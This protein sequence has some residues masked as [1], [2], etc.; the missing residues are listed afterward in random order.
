MNL[1]PAQDKM[2]KGGAGEAKQLAMEILTKVGDA[3]GAESLVPIKSAH[4]LAH[5]SSLH[6]A[7][8]E[9]LER[10]AMAGGKFAVPTTVDPASIDLDNWRSFGIPE[11]YAEK[12]LRLCRAYAKMGGI[13]CWTCVQYQVCNFP[14]AGEVVAWAE[15]SSVVFANSL[16]GCRT[17]KIT[18][19]LDLAC[20]LTGLTPK[21]GMLLDEN[22]LATIAFNVSVGKLTDL[23]LR[24]I[25]F[26]LGKEAGA[27]VPALEGLPATATSDE[28]K[29][30]GAAAAASGPITM[31]H[32][33]G[34]TPGSDSVAQAS[35][36][37]RLEVVNIERS[38]LDDVEQEL[39]QTE[40][41]PDLVALGVPHL[42]VNELGEL[43]KLLRG[44]RLVQGV[45][46]Y[47]YTSAQAYDMA[48]R[49]G[50]KGE[51]ES[52]GARLTHSTDAEISPLKRLGFNVV[53]TNS[54]KLAEIVSSEGEVKLRYAPLSK[55]I[56][57]VTRA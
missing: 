51:I 50:I 9:M 41:R 11:D 40:E 14:K 27:K 13:P 35:G 54:A 37:Q 1:E 29:H 36:G 49:S 47:V 19:G 42:S 31:I 16:I 48:A 45:K 23:D 20:S 5:Y 39:N 3:V 17:N 7:G 25:G 24:S 2:L 43:A 55:I 53:M 4:V 44:R 33:L 26:V 56:A 52:S 46:M 28:L 18:S 10:F 8:I 57:E 38:D 32:Y 15:S 30:L 12:Q 6:E 21:F 22:R 34:I